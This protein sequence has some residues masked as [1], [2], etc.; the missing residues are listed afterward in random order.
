MTEGTRRRQVRA[1]ARQSITRI[2]DAAN[3][4]FTDDPQA[5]L[6]QVAEAAGVGRATVHRH[7]SSRR[8]LLDALVSDLNARY[9]EAFQQARVE[10]VPP[11]VALYRLTEGAFELKTAHPFVIGLTP[12]ARSQ[13]A[14]ASDPTIREGL[15]RLFG[16]LYA[17]GEIAVDDPVWCRMVYLALLHEV[18]ELDAHAP[19]LSGADTA[20]AEDVGARVRLLVTS[21]IGALGGPRPGGAGGSD[22]T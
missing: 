7:F 9:R 8:A 13:G 3:A 16:R 20:P 2:L 17:A 6:E 12:T 22:R 15:E 11:L 14:P 5:S 1:D 18:H 10:S 19:V 21:L 4:V